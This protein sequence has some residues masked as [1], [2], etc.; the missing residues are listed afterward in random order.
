[1]IEN[2]ILRHAESEHPNECCGIVV[3]CNKSNELKYMPFKNMAI[4][5]L[6]Q[7]FIGPM[8]YIS[9]MSSGEI[10][11]IVHSHPSASHSRTLSHS[12]RVSQMGVNKPYW[13]VVDGVIKKYPPILK[14]K[15][16]KFIEGEVDCYNIFKD[17]YAFCG[18]EMGEYSKAEGYRIGEWWK[19]PGAT[20]PYLD[21]MEKE[22]FYK[23][24]LGEIL[25][26]DVILSYLCCPLVNHAMIYFGGN[27]IFHHLPNRL[28]LIEPLR[29]YF[30]KM[31]DSVWRHKDYKSL[32]IERTINFI[33]SK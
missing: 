24:K 6:N 17:F 11:A 2:I 9:A 14:F 33:R 8:D 18:L 28:S 13:L 22:G 21:N 20:S 25:P 16:R 12:D 32:E 30:I 5:K 23:V 31:K 10:I 4:D 1:M 27:E 7:F 3:K 15:K 29:D 19:A 26:G